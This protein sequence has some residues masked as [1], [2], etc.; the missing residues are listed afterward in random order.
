MIGAFSSLTAVN[1]RRLDVPGSG[2]TSRHV[3]HL[4]LLLTQAK[5]VQHFDVSLNPGLHDALPL[6]LSAARSLKVISFSGIPID[7]QELIEMAQ[8]LQSNTSLSYLHIKSHSA[9]RYNLESLIKFV[10]IVTAPESKSRLEVLVFGEYKED[11]AAVMLSY[12]LKLMAALH[13]HKLAV[14]PICLDTD[15]LELYS[16]GREQILMANRMSHSLLYGKK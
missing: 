6:F 14:V 2:L 7:D 9:M 5:Y 10:E 12:L 11:K 15:L 8:V 3:Y 1:C 4:I 16:L 13:G